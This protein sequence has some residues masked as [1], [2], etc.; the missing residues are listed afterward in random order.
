MR[1]IGPAQAEADLEVGDLHLHHSIA[2]TRDGD[3]L[4][5]S[6]RKGKPAHLVMIDVSGR[7]SSASPGNQRLVDCGEMWG[8]GEEGYVETALAGTTGLDGTVYFG[9]P[10]KSDKYPRDHL[11]W[12]LIILPPSSWL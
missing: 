4:Y 10:R 1:T 3:V 9:G 6:A 12:A 8:E 5:V 2:L 11:R 7:R